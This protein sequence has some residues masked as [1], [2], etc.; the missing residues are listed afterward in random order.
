MSE[1]G[2][3]G[4]RRR[5]VGQWRY[6]AIDE[7]IGWRVAMELYLREN[8]AGA[9]DAAS[10]VAGSMEGRFVG[11]YRVIEAE[12]ETRDTA[13]VFDVRPWLTLEVAPLESAL[14]VDHLETAILEACDEVARE[15]AWEH[16]PATRVTMLSREV[17]DP[18]LPN[19]HGYCVDKVE[20]TKICLPVGLTADPEELAGAVR[21][22][23]A[24]VMTGH[25]TQGRCPR[26]LDEVFAM[27]AERADLSFRDFVVG[28]ARWLKEQDLDR[29]FQQDRTSREGAA[30]VR[31]AYRQSAAIGD[32]LMGLGSQEKMGS[33]LDAFSDNSLLGELAMRVTG[34]SYSDEALRQTYGF[35]V[36]ELFERA[37]KSLA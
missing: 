31:Q 35:G 22:E 17:D 21:H 13:T 20:Y 6:G 30:V 7:S 16:G 9:V 37:F 12:K 11:F 14:S 29:A 24:H 36:E 4:D 33:L 18:W 34:Q 25:R 5:V 23:Y 32:Y 8:L 2:Q 10:E 28:H 1:T 26:W 19:R 3:V 27:T 15:F